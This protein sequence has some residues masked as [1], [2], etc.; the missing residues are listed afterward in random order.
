MRHI[1]VWE[2]D[3]WGSRMLSPRSCTNRVK[4]ELVRGRI[5]FDEVKHELV[6]DL[7]DLDQHG[8]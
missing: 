7:T 6:T 2:D 5:V 3:E 8:S 4:G 1:W